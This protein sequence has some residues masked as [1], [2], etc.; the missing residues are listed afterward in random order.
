MP[1]AER[2][3]TSRRYDLEPWEVIPVN[4]SDL[5]TDEA[6]A[7][8]ERPDP[9]GRWETIPWDEAKAHVSGLQARISRAYE[10]GETDNVRR[11]QRLLTHS[12]HA[13][14]LAVRQVTT[15]D[16]RNTPGVDGEL[17]RTGDR[18]LEAARSLKVEGYRAKPLK[19][20][21]VPKKKPGQL[22]PLGIPTMHDRAMQALFAL[23]L[24]PVEE[25]HADR[26]SFGFRRGRC[27]QDA[28]ARLF[29][30]MARRTSPTYVLEGDIAG[31]FD[32]IDHQ[33]LLDNVP[34][35]KRVL[36]QFLRAGFMEAGSWHMTESGTPQ[37]GPISGVLANYALDG[38]EGLLARRFTLNARGNR[39]E[40]KAARNRVCLTRYADDFVVTAATPEVAEEVRGLLEPFLKERG[41]TLSS[42]KT[43]VT[44][45][46][47]GFD[48]LGWN[49]RK[50]GG[51]LL[52]KP[53]KDSVKAFLRKTHDVIL[54]DGKAMGP[55]DLIR[56][57][58][59]KVRGFAR[60]HRHTCCSQTFARIAYVMNGQLWKWGSRRHPNKTAKW[61]KR[62]YW[63]NAG[64][65]NNMFG[66]PDL[67]LRPI[68]W[69]HV[70]RHPQLRGDANPYLDT[71]YFAERRRRASARNARALRMPAVDVWQ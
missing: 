30:L 10:N 8:D 20:T 31:C 49:F 5:R 29:S 33:W 11:L 18:K 54:R 67:Y 40:R 63:C 41:L 25:A 27:T 42:E 57:L 68:T 52:I 36:A 15:A 16:G 64:G 4:G 58:E 39:D 13:R 28:C 35:D 45:I 71:E 38:M 19:R 9:Y 22:R 62:R 70:V 2:R 12:F 24:D 7:T 50:Y 55:E 14:L 66:T 60:H 59:P 56:V 47:D 53:S 21:Y 51:K 17:W 23:V 61:L 26:S 37:G 48:F 65:N 3:Q 32:H 34:M 69:D 6:S 43:L 46:D 44:H 1:R